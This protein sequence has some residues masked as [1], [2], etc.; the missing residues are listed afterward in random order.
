MTWFG[1][2]VGRGT[3][4]GLSA[5]IGYTSGRG[6]IEQDGE[7]GIDWCWTARVY[8]LFKIFVKCVEPDV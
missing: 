7:S 6:T 2:P 1:V 8:K 5:A 4:A 3:T